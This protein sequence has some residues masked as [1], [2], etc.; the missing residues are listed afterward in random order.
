MVIL[1]FVNLEVYCEALGISTEDCAQET[2]S[3]TVII[4][5]VVKPRRRVKTSYFSNKIA[6]GFLLSLD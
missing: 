3:E 6:L 4:W 5:T 2:R 1:E